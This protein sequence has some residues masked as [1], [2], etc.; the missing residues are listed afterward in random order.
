MLG[1]SQSEQDRQCSRF[2]PHGA[3]TVWPEGNLI[4]LELKGPFNREFFASLRSLNADLYAD[5]NSQGPFVEIAVFHHSMLMSSA[6]I[7]EFGAVLLERK[8]T[9]HAPLATAWVISPEIK[10]AFVVLP[11]VT[12][13]FEQAQRPFMWFRTLREAEEWVRG[14]LG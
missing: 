7:D 4:R 6:T 13:K 8:K 14:F 10:D 3:I 1:K 5:L 2:K 12:K 9:G 11:H